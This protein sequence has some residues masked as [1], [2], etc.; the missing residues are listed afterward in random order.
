MCGGRGCRK[1][2][3]ADGAGILKLLCALLL[4]AAFYCGL[5]WY[6]TFSALE[7][8]LP[9]NEAGTCGQRQQPHGKPDQRSPLGGARLAT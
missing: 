7:S 6:R 5:G 9:T 8:T 2:A 4:G 3:D 1:C